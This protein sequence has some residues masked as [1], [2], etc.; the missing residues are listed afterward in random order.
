MVLEYLSIV[1]FSLVTSLREILEAAL[2]IG[3]ILGYLKVINRND[4]R[5]DVLYGVLSAVFFSLALGLF[6]VVLSNEFQAFEKLFEAFI[7]LIAAAM[8]TWVVLWINTQKKYVRSNLESKMGSIISKKQRM[9]FFLLVF[10]SVARE[11]AELVLLLYSSYISFVAESGFVITISSIFIGF[12]AGVSLAI[13]MTLIMYKT[14]YKLETKKFF[15]ITSVILIVFAAGLI[16]HGLH[17]LFEY[18][19][20]SGSTLSSLFIWTELWNI[21]DT[22]LGDI[23]KFFFGWSYNP[24]LPNRFEKS[25]IGSILV[26]LFGWNDNPSLIEV[27]AY[28]TYLLLIVVKMKKINLNDE[29]TI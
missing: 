1:L 25:V 8:I 26:G 21:N 24:F 4:L 18:F 9:S 7:M 17:E 20:T 23:L 3:I 27:V 13:I 2:I 11:G 6:F 15:A 29:K 22:F 16:V 14:S 5:R 12:L 28:L 10:F 19:E